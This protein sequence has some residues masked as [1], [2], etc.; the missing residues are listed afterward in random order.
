MANIKRHRYPLSLKSK[1]M[2]LFHIALK[3]L[4]N[5]FLLGVCCEIAAIVLVMQNYWLYV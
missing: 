3:R 2:A 5:F 1:K 4:G